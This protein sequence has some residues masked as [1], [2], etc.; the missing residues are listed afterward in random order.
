LSCGPSA[1]CTANILVLHFSRNDKTERLVT[2]RQAVI[3]LELH[4]IYTIEPVRTGKA[5]N[6]QP[7]LQPLISAHTLPGRSRPICAQ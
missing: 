5:A 4:S 6:L 1:F 7:T 3:I 2:L